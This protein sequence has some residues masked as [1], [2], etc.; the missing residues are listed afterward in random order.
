MPL[1]IVSATMRTLELIDV[2]TNDLQRNHKGG[3]SLHATTVWEES[4]ERPIAEYAATRSANIQARQQSV[5]Y[6]T[7][8]RRAAPY[9]M[10]RWTLF[11]VFFCHGML[12][13]MV[14]LS[15]L[16][17]LTFISILFASEP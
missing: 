5:R 9:K 12:S 10:P 16:F 2:A 4:A 13:D 11:F 8:E 3:H 17:R 15:R 14:T 7:Q 6:G 1:P